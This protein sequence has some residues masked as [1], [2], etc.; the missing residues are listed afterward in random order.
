M[1]REGSEKTKGRRGREK[2]RGGWRKKKRDEHPPTPF[3]L[4]LV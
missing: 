3:N 2:R 1:K 4:G